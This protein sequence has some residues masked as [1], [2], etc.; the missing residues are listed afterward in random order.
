[1]RRVV[2]LALLATA[3]VAG[4]TPAGAANGAQLAITALSAPTRTLV[5]GHPVV[6]TVSAANIDAGRVAVDA[7]G[8]PGITVVAANCLTPHGGGAQGINCEQG[9]A[10]PGDHARDYFTIEASP[11]TT[12]RKAKFTVCP[13][14]LDYGFSGRCRSITFALR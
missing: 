1:M 12:V 6:V 2:P 4:S 5:Q 9:L 3:V 13:V 10:N 7:T 8:A 14:D 11:G